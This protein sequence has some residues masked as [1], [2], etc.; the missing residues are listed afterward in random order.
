MTLAIGLLVVLPVWAEESNDSGDFKIRVIQEDGSVDEVSVRKPEPPPEPQK[1]RPR[2][3]PPPQQARAPHVKESD[4]VQPS[5]IQPTW[6]EQ[7]IHYIP[8]EEEYESAEPVEDQPPPTKT[9]YA[10]APEEAGG[11]IPL[12]R[13]KPSVAPQAPRPGTISADLAANI[14]L[15]NA[16]ASQGFKV[17][18]DVYSGRHVFAVVFKTDT[19]PYEVMI[20]SANGD[21][22]HKGH[23]AAAPQKPVGSKWPV[24]RQ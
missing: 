2:R 17:H 9:S 7:N 18:E 15:D 24:A 21:I 22:V 3:R 8:A 11:R 14:A 5:D 13:R 20:D 1:A 12:P 6:T 4:L 19:G 23:L 10:P 16:P